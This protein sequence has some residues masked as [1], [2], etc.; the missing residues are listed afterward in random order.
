[1]TIDECKKT[2]EDIKNNY[3]T[4]FDR[5]RDKKKISISNS[6]SFLYP[7][8][9]S[10]SVAD[11]IVLKNYD[12]PESKYYHMN[13]ND[14]LELWSRKGEK[15][16]QKGKLLDFFME[17]LYVNKNY[18]KDDIEDLKKYVMIEKNIE[19][20]SDEIKLFFT[21]YKLLSSLHLKGIELIDREIP[22][23]YESKEGIL[24]GRIDAI[25]YNH[26]T[27]KPI[28]VDWKSNSE[29]SVENN[30]EKMLGPCSHLDNC[31]L[32]KFF[33]QV[34]SYIAGFMQHSNEIDIPENCIIQVLPNKAK[35]HLSKF[36]Y[37]QELIDK[38]IFYSLYKKEN[39]K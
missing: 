11:K 30:F 2:I 38:M 39:S 32:N 9:D 37:N 24:Y 12:N 13:K 36:L 21:C 28:I 10:D 23:A 6:I 18:L 35:I 22:V 17:S 15:G 14:I 27:L 29:I 5:N 1:M 16:K 33:L 26:N 34:Y 8:F 31:D 19:E 4:V 3:S 25:F 7:S 20:D